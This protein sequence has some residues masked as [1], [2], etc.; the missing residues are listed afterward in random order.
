MAKFLFSTLPSSGHVHPISTVAAKLVERG[1]QVWWHTSESVAEK[2]EATGARFIAKRH[3][4]D[5]GCDVAAEGVKAE[6]IN[7]LITP[8]RGQLQDY[9]EIL[10]EFPADV[11]VTDM[12]HMGAMMLHEQGGPP[13]ATIGVTPLTT[14]SPDV[15]PWGTT[16][17]PTLSSFDRLS[18]RFFH[19]MNG[20]VWLRSVTDALN[21]ERRLSGLP[22]LPRG[23]AILDVTISP[24][25]HLQST[26]ASF[27]YPRRDMPPQAHFVGTLLPTIA[28]DF[29]PP[30]WWDELHA[31][32]PVVLVTQGT[33]STTETDL[34]V[35]ALQALADEDVLVV[36]TTSKPA[37]LGPL[38]ANSRVEEFIPYRALMPHVDVL[39]SNGGYNG[40]Q[41]ALS[42]GRPLVVGGHTEDKPDVCARVAWAG[43]GINLKTGLPSPEQ[44]RQAV[45]TVLGDPSYRRNAERFQADF[46]RHDGPA[47]AAQALEQF[48]RSKTLVAAGGDQMS[49]RRRDLAGKPIA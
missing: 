43:V 32:R 10:Q 4:P 48:A 5:L 49:S 42:Y 40:V 12:C 33:V 14:P 30:A 39:I 29:T 27:E 3:T 38:P 19:W 9:Q 34:I 44:I 13:W 7:L 6:I 24:F 8:M 46:A 28:A 20:H 2:V 23:K 37:D 18:N 17:P 22:P 25:L 16:P 26:V 15:P 1:H 45:R 35:P 11:L 31:N 21:Q 41:T 36:A 47:E